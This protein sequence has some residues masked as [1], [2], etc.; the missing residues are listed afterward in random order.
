MVCQLT[1]GQS[2][3]GQLT[4]HQSFLLN[5]EPTR[6]YLLKIFVFLKICQT[7]LDPKKFYCISL[8]FFQILLK[9]SNK[10]EKK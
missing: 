3:I 1:V 10:R 4:L 2:Y 8:V 5:P 6:V 7:V 9:F